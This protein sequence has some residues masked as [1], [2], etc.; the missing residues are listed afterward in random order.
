M[1]NLIEMIKN[2]PDIELFITRDGKLHDGN[3]VVSYPD[4]A[5]KELKE[6]GFIEIDGIWK[7]KNE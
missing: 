7:L 4:D 1:I 6:M 2:N 3:H 5:V